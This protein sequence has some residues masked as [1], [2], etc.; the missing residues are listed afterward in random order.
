ML[1]ENDVCRNMLFHFFNH[2]HILAPSINVLK[3]SYIFTTLL[4]IRNTKTH[5]CEDV[6]IPNTQ[7]WEVKH[8]K[9]TFMGIQQIINYRM[10]TR[11]ADL[12][13]FN[14]SFC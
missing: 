12:Y 4:R 9:N 6:K 11:S 14:A 1:H 8:P 2:A 10:F 7:V 13:Y 3:I 5:S